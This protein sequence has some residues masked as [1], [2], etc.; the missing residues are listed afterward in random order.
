MNTVSTRSLDV[1]AY[2]LAHG[3]RLVKAEESGRIFNFYFADTPELQTDVSEWN[4]GNSPL[5]NARTFVTARTHLLDVINGR[6][7]VR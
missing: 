7:T 2:L 3:H 4:F 6:G 5:V 1:A